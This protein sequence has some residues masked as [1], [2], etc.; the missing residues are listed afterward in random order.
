MHVYQSALYVFVHIVPESIIPLV[1]YVVMR[2]NN[3]HIP[4]I[5]K[6][7]LVIQNIKH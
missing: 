3:R 1:F 6:N 7:K 2:S 4:L 5:I